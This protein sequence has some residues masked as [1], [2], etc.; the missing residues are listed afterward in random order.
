LAGLRRDNL[1]DREAFGE[2]AVLARRIEPLPNVDFVL[3][4]NLLD[5]A[6]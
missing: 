3:V 6:L 2:D 5:G 1:A 4:L